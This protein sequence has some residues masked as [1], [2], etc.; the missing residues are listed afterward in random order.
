MYTHV[1]IS[2]YR[3][4]DKPTGDFCH[5][6]GGGDRRLSAP[7]RNPSTQVGGCTENEALP[8]MA[9]DKEAEKGRSFSNGFDDRQQ[10]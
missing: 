4:E 5:E 2:I 3:T 9:I 6:G 8:G 10:A 1:Y 7:D